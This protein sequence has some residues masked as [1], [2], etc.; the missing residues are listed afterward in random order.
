MPQN[1]PIIGGKH[2][3]SYST[4]AGST[5]EPQAAEVFATP[6]AKGYT[7]PLV[8]IVAFCLLLLVLFRLWGFQA[9]VSARIGTS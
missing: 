9:L 5:Q 7:A 4:S 1:N 6:S 2:I 3:S 8:A